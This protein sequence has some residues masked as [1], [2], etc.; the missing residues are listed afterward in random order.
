MSWLFNAYHRVTV[1]CEVKCAP[2]CTNGKHFCHLMHPKSCNKHMISRKTALLHCTC[3][4]GLFLKRFLLFGLGV[5]QH[6]FL[7]VF[8]GHSN[9]KVMSCLQVVRLHNLPWFSNAHMS[10]GSLSS[11]YSYVHQD[12]KACNIAM[13]S[14]CNKLI[15]HKR[16]LTNCCSECCLSL[17]SRDLITA[18]CTAHGNLQ[19]MLP[20]LVLL[21]KT[22]TTCVVA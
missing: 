8:V 19:F 20:T 5:R 6:H 17:S 1:C 4:L 15:Q 9:T 21:H 3:I 13:T 12:N 7:S 14:Q 22:L 16:K 2:A 11:I 10:R 18:S